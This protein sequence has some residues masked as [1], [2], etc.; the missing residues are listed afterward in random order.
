MGKNKAW[1]YIL[2]YCLKRKD[3]S[4]KS[5]LGKY[6]ILYK[7]FDLLSAHALPDMY[8]AYLVKQKYGI[9]FM[10]TWHGSDINIWPFVS[11]KGFETTKLLMVNADYNFFCE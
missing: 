2:T 8:L 6:V 9:P 5:Q 11:K 1:D 4:C 7:N 10:N 3:I